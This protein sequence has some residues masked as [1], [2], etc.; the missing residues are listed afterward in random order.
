[1]TCLVCGSRQSEPH[2][3]GISCRA[4]AAFFR[5]F[6]NSKKLVIQCVCKS[7]SP[8]AYP[9]RMCRV[10]KCL[11]IGMTPKRIHGSRDPNGK[12]IRSPQSEPSTSISLPS[13]LSPREV[14]TITSSLSNFLDYEQKRCDIFLRP[15]MLNLFEASCLTKK[16]IDLTYQFVGSAFPEFQSLSNSDRQSLIH[17]FLIKI[18]NIEPILDHVANRIEYKKME[19]EGMRNYVTPLYRGSFQKGAEMSEEQ[20]WRTFGVYWKYYYTK[21]IDPIAAV[22]LDQTEL[23]AI[24][25]IM[26]FDQAFI[27]ISPSSSDFCWTQRKVILKEL[28][29]YEME[30]NP[31]DYESRF[32]EILEIPEFMERGEKQFHEEIIVGEMWK[33]RMHDDFKA[34]MRRQR[35]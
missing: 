5:R 15:N 8:S 4:C 35:I 10:A 9:C 32:L 29:N 21:M 30:K 17:N 18:W 7:K 3:G 1:M 34:V 13:S 12:Y 23:L 31:E 20:I 33:M 2:F 27:N 14:F 26:F 22:D 24:L 19:D 16:D 11:A 6:Y 28:R 25:L